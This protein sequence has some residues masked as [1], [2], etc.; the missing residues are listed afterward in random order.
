MDK[1]KTKGD[2]VETVEETSKVTSTVKTTELQTA[3]QVH[4]HQLIT[5]VFKLVVNKKCRHGFL[6]DHIND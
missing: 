4:Y 6:Y 2:T 5:M 1:T 3:V